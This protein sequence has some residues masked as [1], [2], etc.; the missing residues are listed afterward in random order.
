MPKQ[1]V[2]KGAI[3]ADPALVIIK[4]F[5]IANK[6]AGEAKKALMDY[7]AAHPA[8]GLSDEPDVEENRLLELYR[9]FCQ[10]LDEQKAK[11]EALSFH[12]WVNFN[13]HTGHT[14]TIDYKP[15]P[16]SDNNYALFTHKLDQQRAAVSNSLGSMPGDDDN[17]EDEVSLN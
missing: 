11:A 15:T 12:I 17:D 2:S 6:R 4:A 16:E 14:Y 5:R 10:K 9:S 3:T 1:I 8:I 13:G 7:Q